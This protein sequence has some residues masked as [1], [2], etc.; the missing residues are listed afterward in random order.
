MNTTVEQRHRVFMFARILYWLLLTANTKEQTLS[1]LGLSCF[2]NNLGYNSSTMQPNALLTDKAVSGATMYS[3][4]PILVWDGGTPYFYTLQELREGA[5]D[6]SKGIVSS[7]RTMLPNSAKYLKQ[8][9]M[10]CYSAET[11]GITPNVSSHGFNVA[12]P[13]DGEDSGTQ[14]SEAENLKALMYGST[15][16]CQL[17]W[18]SDKWVGSTLG[19]A[20]VIF[21]ILTSYA[22]F[23]NVQLNKK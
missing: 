21:A 6:P 15:G 8:I 22:V 11:L 10:W 9:T 17:F 1:Q 4:Q 5:I 18:T 16:Y 7:K 19:I 14:L 12:V 13:G 3:T 23:K 2:V 20:C